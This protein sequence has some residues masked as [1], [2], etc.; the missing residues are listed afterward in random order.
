MQM[1]MSCR[2]DFFSALPSTAQCVNTDPPLGIKVLSR[3][4]LSRLDR[5]PYLPWPTSS[6]GAMM[7]PRKIK[8]SRK[9]L[10]HCA[11]RLWTKTTRL[12]TMR[13]FNPPTRNR[14]KNTVKLIERSLGL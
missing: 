8:L 4:V 11:P 6:S 2:V 14:C 12:G 13:V 1:N 9:N 7:P 10:R 3:E 5:I